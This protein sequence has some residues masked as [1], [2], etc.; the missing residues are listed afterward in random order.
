MYRFIVFYFIVVCL[1]LCSTVDPWGTTFVPLYVPTCSGMTIKL[2]LN[3]NFVFIQPLL[4][5]ILAFQG[6]LSHIASISVYITQLLSEVFLKKY[7]NTFS[8]DLTWI[9]MT[10]CITKK[11]C[12]CSALELTLASSYIRH[13]MRLLVQFYSK[14]TLNHHQVFVITSFCD[15]IWNLVV[16][17]C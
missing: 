3:L 1:Y 5:F 7:N 10:K 2:N 9:I 15:H 16:Y 12:S 13:F 8:C 6:L 14:L 4:A 17:C 11:N